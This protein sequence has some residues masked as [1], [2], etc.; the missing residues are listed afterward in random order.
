MQGISG[1]FSV[2]GTQ[3]SLQPSEHNWVDRDSLGISGEARPMY[4]AVRK[5]SLQW[6]LMSM[7]EFN[8][9][10]GFYNTV[11]S[12][13]TVVIDLPKYATTP[14]QFYSYSGC[15]L[16]EPTAGKFFTEWVSDVSL[17]ILKIRG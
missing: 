5:Y 11:R 16:Q 10:V 13:G 7:T 8:Q 1:S 15:T 4:P 6:G 9:L 17:L 14:Y 12:S 2:N 3:I